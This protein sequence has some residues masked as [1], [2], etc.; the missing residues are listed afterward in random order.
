MPSDNGLTLDYQPMG[1]GGKVRLTARLSGE[2][3]LTDRAHLAPAGARARFGREPVKARQGIDKKAVAAQLEKIVGDIVAKPDAEGDGEAGED[4][5]RRSHAD[6]LVEMAVGGGAELFHTPGGHD[7][8]GYA[9]VP[10]GDHKETWPVA[11]KGFRRW[12]AR[13]F[14]EARA[15]AVGSQALQDAVN[16]LA[17]MAIHDGREVPVAV[18]VAEQDG[19]IYLDLA[20]A[21]WRAVEVTAAGW[22]IVDNPPVRFCRRRGMLALPAPV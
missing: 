12:L 21:D 3:D 16:V 10:V 14:W 11:S 17:G 22:R 20:D 7:S 13:L 2:A 15:K 1:N 4:R 8:E 6:L 18:R 5:G 9:T 19:A